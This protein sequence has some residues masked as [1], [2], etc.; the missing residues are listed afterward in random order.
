[1]NDTRRLANLKEILELLYEK[2]SA[3]ERELVLTFDA[4][5]KFGREQRDFVNSELN[6]QLHS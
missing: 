1:M 4:S 5:V 2:L 6:S 3:L